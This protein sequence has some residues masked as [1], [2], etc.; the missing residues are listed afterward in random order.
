M[1]T[2]IL[3]YTLFAILVIILITHTT[4]TDGIE[5]EPSVE[6]REIQ[7]KLIYYKCV[8]HIIRK[9]YMIPGNNPTYPKAYYGISVP[10]KYECFIKVLESGYDLNVA[11]LHDNVII[12][13]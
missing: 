9:D 4:A 10:D 13:K 1:R 2:S 8:N 6:K 11:V 3:L 7:A 12:K 5:L